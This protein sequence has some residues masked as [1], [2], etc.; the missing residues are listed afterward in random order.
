[1]AA[2]LEKTRHP[3]I[4]KRGGRYAYTYRSNGKQRW[5]SARTLDAARKEKRAHEA[6]RDRGEL[7]EES[8]IPFVDFA[9]EWIDRYQGT[10]RR[11]FSG[12]TRKDYRRDLERYAYPFL[13]DKLGR[14]VSQI[15]RRDLAR[16]IAWLCDEREQGRRLA[17]ATVRRIVAP[18]QACLST[19]ADEGVVRVNP[20]LGLKLP[21]REQIEEDEPAKVLS[22][23]ELAMF[24]R[25]VHP[26]YRLM[27]RFLAA[28]GLRWSELIGLQWRHLQPDGSAPHVK[29]RR[30]ISK[31][32]VKAPKSRHGRRDVPLSRELVSELRRHRAKARWSGDDD[33]VFASTRGN[34][35]NHANVSRRYLKP[36]AEEAGV[37]WAG[38]HT[39][40]HTCASLLFAR[41][42]NAKQVQRW[43][44]HHSPAF[45]L[46]RY[47]SIL[48]G[49]DAEAL[50]LGA[51]LGQGANRVRTHQA[52]THR[53]QASPDRAVSLLRSEPSRPPQAT[54]SCH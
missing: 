46:N 12:Q 25:V 34:P 54:R 24:L 36:A 28:T 48:P 8:R 15:T 13:G 41:G 51:E 45:T 35:P 43:L 30:A 37:A 47:I 9:A 40:R 27:F 38:F 18:V 39:F 29:V 42:A 1:M 16:W 5:G 11:G 21:V 17:D 31:G 22:R 23:D 20:A 26:D 49:E 7:Q 2:R 44:G 14:T 52:G 4:Y 53:N 10:G 3:G 33:P 6:D 19:A 50:D 32:T